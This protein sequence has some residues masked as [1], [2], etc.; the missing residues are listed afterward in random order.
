MHT[1]FENAT[2]VVLMNASGEVFIK[3]PRTNTQLR[4][5]PHYSGFMCT[6][7]N[8]HGHLE[9]YSMNGLPAFVV[10]RQGK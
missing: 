4:V 7:G 3:D 10:I 2:I 5:S 9:P 8:G 1:L 6:S